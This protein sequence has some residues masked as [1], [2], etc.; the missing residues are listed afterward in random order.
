M[1]IYTPLSLH[2]KLIEDF[3]FQNPTMSQHLWLYEGVTDY[4]SWLIKMQ[5]GLI[6]FEDF[7]FE[8]TRNKIITANKFKEGLSIIKFSEDIL[9]EANVNEFMQIYNKGTILAM[10]LDLEIRRLSNGSKELKELLFS[11]T[12]KY[13]NGKSFNEDEIIPEIV[14]MVHPDLQKFFDNYIVGSAK[15]NYTE[16]FEPFGIHYIQKDTLKV[17]LTILQDGNGVKK[18]LQIMGLYTI[19]KVEKTSPFKQGDKIKEEVMG[20]YCRKPFLNPDGTFFNEG[21]EASI[22]ILRDGKEMTLK[23]TPEFKNMEFNYIITVDENMSKDQRFLFD[24]WTNNNSEIGE[25]KSQ[26]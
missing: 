19:N 9:V 16:I 15:I 1:H 3:D 11:L 2:S 5:T 6:S 12:E 8:I 22:D 23:I 4:M 17:P 18:A 14:S 26:N 24:Y 10:M 13:S 21:S 20:Y 7:L 25:Y